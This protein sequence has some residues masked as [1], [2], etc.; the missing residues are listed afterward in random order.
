MSQIGHKYTPQKSPL[1][2]PT[3]STNPYTRTECRNYDYIY[4]FAIVA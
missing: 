3:E 1:F 2:R 4:S